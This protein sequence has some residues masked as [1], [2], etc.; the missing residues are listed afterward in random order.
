ML[1]Q[2]V[3]TPAGFTPGPCNGCGCMFCA[4][5]CN[6]WIQDCLIHVRLVW[7]CSHCQCHWVESHHCLTARYR[8]YHIIHA[9][10]PSPDV[11]R[12][13]CRA[14][15]STVRQMCNW[16]RLLGS[17]RQ[18][19]CRVRKCAISTIRIL[20]H[21]PRHVICLCG[22]PCHCRSHVLDYCHHCGHHGSTCCCHFSSVKATATATTHH[23]T[24]TLSLLLPLPQLPPPLI[25][26]MQR[27]VLLWL[28]LLFAARIRIT[29]TVVLFLF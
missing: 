24:P 2:I 25:M 12:C 18:H 17:R 7:P 19:T 16:L 5:H 9:Y 21:A 3:P 6:N 13:Y 26:S 22:R 8:W 27:L 15:W 14:L 23:R 4:R 1:L 11:H 28:H 10:S 20:D 29:I